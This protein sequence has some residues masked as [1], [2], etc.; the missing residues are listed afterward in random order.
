MAGSQ[1]PE[2]AIN[3]IIS[4]M[5]S[6]LATEM[7]VID[8]LWYGNDTISLETPAEYLRGPKRAYPD[9]PVIIVEADDSNIP[10]RYRGENVQAVQFGY[11]IQ[12]HSLQV[13]VI[14]RSREQ[15]T[16]QSTTLQPSEVV[17]IRMA[18]TM[19]A[20]QNLLEKNDKLLVS[21]T[22]N[23]DKMHVERIR[24]PFVAGVPN[25]SDLFEKQGTMDLLVMISP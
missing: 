10:N 11:N 2:N 20:I 22:Q 19:H 25:Q 7:A 14:I 17:N 6:S 9:Y 18:R 21:S 15:V 1:N 12:F 8:A 24:Y 16:Y 5:N 23:C 4:L 3:A 13:G